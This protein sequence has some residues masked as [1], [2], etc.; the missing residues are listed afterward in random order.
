MAKTKTD[1]RE[2]VMIDRQSSA[3]P[4]RISTVLP[5]F[6]RFHQVDLNLTLVITLK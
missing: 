5:I 3:L 4:V 2:A 6:S 1:M